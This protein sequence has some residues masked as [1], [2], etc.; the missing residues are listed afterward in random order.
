MTGVL[1]GIGTCL[2]EPELSVVVNLASFA[3]SFGILRTWKEVTTGRIE[4]LDTNNRVH[5]KGLIKY[6]RAIVEL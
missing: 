5:A 3:E 6:R 4:R 2:E 1:A